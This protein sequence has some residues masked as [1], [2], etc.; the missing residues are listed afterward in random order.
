MPTDTESTSDQQSQPAGIDAGLR[1]LPQYAR[2]LLKIKVPVAVTLATSREPISRIVEL[3]PGTIIQFSK[4]CDELMTL[5]VG[6][7][8]V[9]DGEAV[10][11]GDKYGIR[12]TRM[13]MPDEQFEAIGKRRGQRS[14]VSGQQ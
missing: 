9:A 14:A 6:N 13:T 4:L 12:I 3:T 1:Q 7:H 8:P 5:E 11:V 10:K 2:S